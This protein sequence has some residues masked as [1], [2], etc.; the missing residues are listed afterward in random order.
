MNNLT[1]LNPSKLLEHVSKGIEELQK[2]L[3]KKFKNQTC[4]GLYVHICCLVERLVT[5]QAITS[6][7]DED[8]EKNNQQFITS[9]KTA[10]KDVEKFYNVEIPVEEIEY[11]YEYVRNDG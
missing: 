3:H 9:L 5:R 1:I 10:M 2:I 7:T 4:F 11:I 6:F 8:F